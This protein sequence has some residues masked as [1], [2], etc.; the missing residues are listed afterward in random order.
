MCSGGN[1]PNEYERL[2]ALIV[3]LKA[4]LDEYDAAHPPTEEA[5][6]ARRH[7]RAVNF[8]DP[9]T[10][11]LDPDHGDKRPHEGPT[12]QTLFPEVDPSVYTSFTSKLDRKSVV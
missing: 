11:Q 12:L 2:T 5:L 4:W 8:L 3:P 9:S 10:S 1:P 6:E 7:F